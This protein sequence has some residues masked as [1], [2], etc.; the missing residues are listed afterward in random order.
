[1]MF[2]LQ[3]TSGDFSWVHNPNVQHLV[4]LLSVSR[5]NFISYKERKRDRCD[6]N[7][8]SKQ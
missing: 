2:N 6:E 3:C 8:L 4:L 5:L 1:M 7:R